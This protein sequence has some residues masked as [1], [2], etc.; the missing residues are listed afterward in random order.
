MKEASDEKKAVPL[1]P[2]SSTPTL[3]AE[4]YSEAERLAVFIEQQ[5]N[6]QCQKLRD[7]KPQIEAV[8]EAFK[9]LKGSKTIAGCRSFPEFCEKKLHRTKQAV[10]AMLGGYSNKPKKDGSSTGTEHPQ[11]RTRQQKLNLAHEDVERMRTG[12][13]AA[14]RYFE[15]EAAGNEQEAESAKQEFFGISK[16]ESLKSVIFGDQPDFKVLLIELLSEVEKVG[17]KLPVSL[18]RTCQAMRKRLG[19]DDASFGLTAW[20]R[21]QIKETKQVLAAQAA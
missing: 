10:Y 13:N 21:Y 8:R 6:E 11:Q 3:W 9:T 14:V 5:F 7:L 4:Y 20:D 2:E 1:P 12:C 19:V 18:T 16:A 17:E 15:A